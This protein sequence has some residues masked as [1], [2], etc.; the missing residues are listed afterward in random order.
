VT[1][2]DP[3]EFVKVTAVTLPQKT[4]LLMIQSIMR[5]LIFRLFD[6]LSHSWPVDVSQE[7]YSLPFRATVDRGLRRYILNY[8]VVVGTGAVSALIWVTG[9]AVIVGL[10]TM[11]IRVSVRAFGYLT[12]YMIG[13]LDLGMNSREHK[14]EMKCVEVSLSNDL[15]NESMNTFCRFP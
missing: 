4:K 10:A 3:G 11:Q 9:S 14:R 13:L 8:N 12:F 15:L 5:P 1:S 6:I 2:P 7:W